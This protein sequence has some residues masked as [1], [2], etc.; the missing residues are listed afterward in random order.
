MLYM[1]KGKIHNLLWHDLLSLQL[2]ILFHEIHV[3]S[4]KHILKD[5]AIYICEN[6]KFEDLDIETF[7][8]LK[9]IDNKS[10]DVDSID[11]LIDNDDRYYRIEFSANRSYPIGLTGRITILNKN[12]SGYYGYRVYFHTITLKKEY[13]NAQIINRVRIDEYLDGETIRSETIKVDRS[14]IVSHVYHKEH[15]AQLYKQKHHASRL[16]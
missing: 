9:S 3:T 10:Y 5:C 4:F 12:K 16:K 11:Y 13:G 14:T 2:E 1:N 15:Y 6:I 8:Q 7:N